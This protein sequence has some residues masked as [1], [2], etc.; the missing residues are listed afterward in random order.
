MHYIKVV[1]IVTLIIIGLVFLYFGPGLVKYLVNSGALRSITNDL[2]EL[3]GGGA[4]GSPTSSSTET[5][6][7]NAEKDA[8]LAAW[9]KT[10]ALD[11]YE[12][13]FSGSVKANVLFI[14]VDAGADGEIAVTDGY[15]EGNVVLKMKGKPDEAYEYTAPFDDGAHMSNNEEYYY[16]VPNLSDFER[17]LIQK[18]PVSAQNRIKTDGNSLTAELT[19]DE[20]KSMFKSVFGF[21]D[22]FSDGLFGSKNVKVS[23]AHVTVKIGA[24]G[25]ISDYDLYIKGCSGIKNFEFGLNSTIRH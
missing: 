17:G 18:L 11:R 6:N 8:Y 13:D 4:P 10:A 14:S 15:H 5:E 25:T 22:D 7:Q 2:S 23:S 19:T 21:I 3:F 24:D 16:A 20:V 1:I 12:V 9:E